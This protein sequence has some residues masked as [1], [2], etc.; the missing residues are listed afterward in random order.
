MNRYGWVL[1][2][3]L[4]ALSGGCASSRPKDAPRDPALADAMHAAAK[5]FREGQP[6]R[7]ER[8]YREALQRARAADDPVAVRDAATS[9][10][11]VLAAYGFSADALALVDEARAAVSMA[12]GSM[13]PVDVVEARIAWSAGN[14]ERA[15]QAAGRVLDSGSRPEIHVARVV[16]AEVAFASGDGPGLDEQADALVRSTLRGPLAAE[17]LR[18]EGYRYQMAGRYEL[19]LDHFRREAEAWHRL[20]RYEDQ[21]RAQRR[22]AAMAA[23]AGRFEEAL[24]RTYRSIRSF[25]ALGR[26]R[27]AADLILGMEPLMIQAGWSELPAHWLRLFDEVVRPSTAPLTP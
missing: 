25:H 2:T 21:A 26:T 3:L 10:G 13:A 27:E 17:R 14:L 4:A 6:D 1:G 7:A 18:V 19:A 5:A 24:D 12:G 22:A 20:D 11:L 9:L 8:F 23:Q 15:R 16:L